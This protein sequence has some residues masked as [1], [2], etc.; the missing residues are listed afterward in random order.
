MA[1]HILDVKFAWQL[2]KTHLL[3][4]YTDLDN[5]CLS[6]DTHMLVTFPNAYCFMNDVSSQSDEFPSYSVMR[7][8]C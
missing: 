8:P 7:F 2:R 4:D 3:A 5:S 1:N 6:R